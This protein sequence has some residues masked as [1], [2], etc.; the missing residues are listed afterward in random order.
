M[1]NRP[2]GPLSP[3][4][5]G[6]PRGPTGPGGPGSPASPKLI[7]PGKDVAFNITTSTHLPAKR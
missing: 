7:V 1:F 2:I 4:G 3:T 5:P 6:T